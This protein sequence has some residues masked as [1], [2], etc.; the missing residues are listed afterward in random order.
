MPTL[1]MVSIQ[2]KRETSA[3]SPG[4]RAARL[5]AKMSDGNAIDIEAKRPP[6]KL[7]QRFPWLRGLV[8]FDQFYPADIEPLAITAYGRD[9]HV[10]SRQPL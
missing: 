10:L 3:A 5:V 7:R 2:K 1:V 9:G 4:P 8:F 6:S